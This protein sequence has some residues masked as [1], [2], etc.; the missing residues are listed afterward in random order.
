ME[1]GKNFNY[2]RQKTELNWNDKLKIKL[3]LCGFYAIVRA[4]NE[5][6]HIFILNSH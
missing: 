3:W 5:K 6:S 2:H 1:T 4:L